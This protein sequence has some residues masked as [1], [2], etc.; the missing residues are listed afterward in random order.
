MSLS[1]L[2]L[3]WNADDSSVDAVAAVIDPKS[4]ELAFEVELVP[5]QYRAQQFFPNRSVHVFNEGVRNRGVRN[6]LG[7]LDIESVRIGCD[8]IGGRGFVKAASAYVRS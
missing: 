5:E 2:L 6:R 8:F 4:R 7:L 1:L 3:R